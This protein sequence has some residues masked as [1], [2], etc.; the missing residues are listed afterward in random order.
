MEM[1]LTQISFGL[2]WLVVGIAAA[3]L[4]MLFMKFSMRSLD[5]A[6]KGFSALLIPLG[7]VLRWA[8]MAVLLYLAI[9]M[10]FAYALLLV[11]AFS[12]ARFVWIYQLSKKAKEEQMKQGDV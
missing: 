8:V 4:F 6:K 3:W 12:I 11:G 1:T 9:R 5:P 2:M 10:H 7:A